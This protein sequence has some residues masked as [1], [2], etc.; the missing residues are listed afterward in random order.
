MSKSNF[1]WLG[2]EGKGNLKIRGCLYPPNSI[3]ELDDSDMSIMSDQV[4]A[5]LEATDQACEDCGCE[6][7]EEQEFDFSGLKKAELLELA[8]EKGVEVKPTSKKA[9]ILDALEGV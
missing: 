4:I 1:K 7:K 8:E 9:D 3:I 6:T 2:F 5:N